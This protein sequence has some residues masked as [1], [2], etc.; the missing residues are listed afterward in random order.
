MYKQLCLHHVKTT[1]TGVEG[2]SLSQNHQHLFQLSVFQKQQIV[3]KRQNNQRVSASGYNICLY[4]R[5]INCVTRATHFIVD[6]NS[7]NVGDGLVTE[8]GGDAIEED[9]ILENVNLEDSIQA[10]DVCK[11]SRKKRVGLKRSSQMSASLEGSGQ[12]STN[13]GLPTEF[14]DVAGNGQLNENGMHVNRNTHIHLHVLLQKCVK[15]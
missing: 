8:A 12:D 1:S 5:N 10:S 14:Q 7:P 4:H 3:L 2:E 15:G 13:G 6:S 9:N 11:H